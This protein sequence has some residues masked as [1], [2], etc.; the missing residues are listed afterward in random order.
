MQSTKS[1][2]ISF[3]WINFVASVF[4][5]AR[6]SEH[7]KQSNQSRYYVDRICNSSTHTHTHTHKNANKNNSIIC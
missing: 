1:E 2:I 6:G 7:N 5:C 3:K 4:H